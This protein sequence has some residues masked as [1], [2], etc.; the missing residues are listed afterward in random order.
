MVDKKLRLETFGRHAAFAREDGGVV[1]QHVEPAEPRFELGGR[2]EDVL[3]AGQ[4]GEE[5]VDVFVS[6][7]ASHKLQ[8]FLAAAGAAA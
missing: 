1:D 4:I 7:L 8:R 3:A 6:R 2:V 5:Q